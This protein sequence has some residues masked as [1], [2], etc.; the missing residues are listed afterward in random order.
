MDAQESRKNGGTMKLDKCIYKGEKKSVYLE[1]GKAVK[2]FAKNYSKTDV[3]YEALNTARVEDSGM[4]I[5]KLLEV[6]IVDGQWAITSEYIEGENLS[7][8]LRKNPGKTDAYL[9]KMVD[10][11]LEINAKQNPLLNKLKDKLNRQINE[12]GELDHSTKYELLTRL[13]SMPK[14]KKLCHGDFCPDN[15][16]VD[17][18]GKFHVVDWVHATQG[19]ASADVARTYLL[20]SLDFPALADKYMDLFCEKTQ[21]KK[22]YVQGWLP[23]VA[24]A[25]LGKH[26]PKE[27]P[28]L[29]KWMDVVD[30]Q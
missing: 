23:I 8:L 4:D 5:P 13:D 19:N 11:Q 6:S 16:I 26:N 14:H 28:L 2:V 24:A 22:S 21:T 25:Q 29:S 15:I 17:K 3:L 12:L 18:D 7:D 1:G 27:A 10:Y 20:L 9:E 30:F